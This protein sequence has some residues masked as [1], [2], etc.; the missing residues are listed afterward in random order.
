MAALADP[1]TAY[2][3]GG[4]GN[5]TMTHTNTNNKTMAMLIEQAQQTFVRT[6]LVTLTGPTGTGKSTLAEFL[7]RQGPDGAEPFICQDAAGLA[8][9]RFESQMFGHVRGAF[10]GA[11]QSF[12]GLVGAAGRGTLVLEGLEDLSHGAQSR[13]LR[14]LQ[15]RRYR[16]VGATRDLDYGGRLIL[17]SRRSLLLLRDALS[18]RDD[19]YF[20]ISATE[21][22]LPA[23][24]A[25]PQDFLELAQALVGELAALLPDCRVPPLEELE[26][27][28]ASRIEG[29][30]HG[31]RNLLQQAMLRGEAPALLMQ[32]AKPPM[33]ELPRTGSFR[34]DLQE[35]ERRLLMRAL[36]EYPVTRYE[37]A[38]LLGISR[39]SL[40][41]KL[42]EHGLLGE[43]G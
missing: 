4:E 40:I 24:A 25:R 37:L 35:M 10:S 11:V 30:L 15:T 13:L 7:H 34:G 17:T 41:Y 5:N 27:L 38:D 33:A 26:E 1:L 43:K 29:N 39:R 9:A 42:K 31:L 6:G 12:A 23:L 36:A 20:R 8:E 19:F 18:M 16:Q 28:D 22:Q 32:P 14:F 2:Y 3:T 21:V